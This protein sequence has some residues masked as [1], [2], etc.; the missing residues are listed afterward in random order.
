MQ[1]VKRK[2][3]R[4]KNSKTKSGYCTTTQRDEC[5]AAILNVMN[6]FFP[7]DKALG[8]EERIDLEHRLNRALNLHPAFKYH[9]KEA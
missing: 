2:P 4:P 3:G 6:E 8:F 9:E 7:L 1:T 5:T